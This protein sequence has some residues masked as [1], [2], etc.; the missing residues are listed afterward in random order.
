MIK[1]EDAGHIANLD[2]PEEFNK[3]IRKFIENENKN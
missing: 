3:I 1:L 2:N